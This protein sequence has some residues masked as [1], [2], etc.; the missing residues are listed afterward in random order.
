MVNILAVNIK[1]SS[2]FCEK[3]EVKAKVEAEINP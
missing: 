3:V 2:T 1:N